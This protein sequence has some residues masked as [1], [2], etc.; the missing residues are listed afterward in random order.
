MSPADLLVIGNFIMAL[1]AC[2]L[3]ATRLVRRWRSK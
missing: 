1:T 3:D 2:V